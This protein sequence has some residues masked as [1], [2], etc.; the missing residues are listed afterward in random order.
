MNKN[1]SEGCGKDKI[2][3]HNTQ[4]RQRKKIQM[5]NSLL[6]LTFMRSKE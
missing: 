4:I 2:T 1:I 5:K 3:E 6:H